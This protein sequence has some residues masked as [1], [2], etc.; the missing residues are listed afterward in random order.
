M[1][2]ARAKETALDQA[3]SSAFTS[4]QARTSEQ[5]EAVLAAERRR[6]EGRAAAC[7]TVWDASRHGVPVRTLRELMET[8]IDASR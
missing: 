2:F 6:A 3:F 7:K 1:L 8:K 5:D 4:L